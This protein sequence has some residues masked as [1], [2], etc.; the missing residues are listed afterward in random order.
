MILNVNLDLSDFLDAEIAVVDRA[1]TI[2][3]FNR[4]WAETARIGLLSPKK[5]NWNYIAECEAGVGRSCSEA[6]TIL[7]G[8]RAVLKGDLVSFVG[9]YGCPFNGLHHWF[10]VQI[11]AFEYDGERQTC[12]T[13]AC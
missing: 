5:S 13:N 1:G 3:H 10:Q 12:H 8:L 11:S 7:V 4:K 6:T 9:N 2:V